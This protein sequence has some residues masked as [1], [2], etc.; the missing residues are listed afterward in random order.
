MTTTTTRA[1]SD[2]HIYSGFKRRAY[3]HIRG[4]ARVQS[5]VCLARSH[6]R[7]LQADLD[8]NQKPAREKRKT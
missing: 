8:I 5:A 6:S 2:E 1:S 3:I 4:P 7:I